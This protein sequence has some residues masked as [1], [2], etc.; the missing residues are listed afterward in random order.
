[1]MIS[2]RGRYAMRIMIELATNEG[3]EY[4]TLREVSENQGISEKY[5]ESIIKI[6]VKDG[7]VFGLRGKG[8]GYKLAK[9]PEEC[10]VGSILKLTEGSLA[11]VSCLE[12][13][14]NGCDRAGDCV[15]LPVWKELGDLIDNY[16]ESIT[17]ANVVSQTEEIPSSDYMI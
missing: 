16:L 2:T 13:D 17:L 9:S 3:K 7:M 1:M 15:T 11:P 5:L 6:L 14:Q 4:M 8:G 12:G 10:T